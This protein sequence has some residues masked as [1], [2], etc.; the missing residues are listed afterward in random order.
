MY[1]Q[2]I[3]IEIEYL[4]INNNKIVS[5]VKSGWQNYEYLNALA[6]YWSL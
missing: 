6:L 4:T 3:A 5:L 2:L 1:I